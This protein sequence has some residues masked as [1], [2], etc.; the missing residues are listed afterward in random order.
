MDNFIVT[1]FAYGTGPYL[2][3]T[4]LAIAF[5]DELEKAG[6]GRMGIIMPWVYGE[7]Q[8]RV[9]LEEF[10]G[11]EKKYPGEILLDAKLGELLRSVFYA[12]C[13][14]EE[15]LAAWVKNYREVSLEAYHHLSF[16]FEVETLGGERRNIDGTKIRV[17]LNRSPRV[18]FNVAPIRREPDRFDKPFA[19]T[20]YP[21]RRPDRA[22]VRSSVGRMLNRFK[23]P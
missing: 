22:R 14:Y 19:T 17:E 23:R 4:D 21:S 13:T 5:N 6:H 1:N 9:M 8:K 3:T 11:H 18:R 15:A 16:E 7:K 12:D 10:T 20:R 2:R